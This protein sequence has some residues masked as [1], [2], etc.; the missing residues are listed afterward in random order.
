[1]LGDCTMQL[2]LRLKA[3]FLCDGHAG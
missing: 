1:M 3:R 2:C